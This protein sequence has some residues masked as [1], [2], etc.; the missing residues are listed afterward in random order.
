[1]ADIRTEQKPPEQ[2]PRPIWPWVAGVIA[3]LVVAW[4]WGAQNDV[5]STGI[6]T[7]GNQ[8]PS[9]PAG[10]TAATGPARE[11]QQFSGV[12]A[13]GKE[14]P[15]M[16]VDH[17]YTA[18]GIRKLAAALESLVD[19]KADAGTRAELERFRRDADRLQEDPKSM[20]HA[21]IVRNVFTSA[22]EVIASI[23]IGP[24]PR[25]L[26]SL[27]ES[28]DPDRPLLGQRDNVRSFLR[29]SA[30]AIRAAEAG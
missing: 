25:D 19:A 21:R 23:D 6:D 30:E 26:R 17:D 10:T 22:A 1:M 12:I 24:A 20:E 3:V 7:A 29:E 15:E 28:I 4:I 9:E 5:A 13:G 27:A 14:V 11:Y 8:P 18:E 2:K 16:S